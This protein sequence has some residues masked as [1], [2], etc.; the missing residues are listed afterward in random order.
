VLFLLKEVALAI[1][2][3]YWLKLQNDFFKSRAMKKIRK[4]AGGDTYTIIYLKLQL[5]SL[6]DEGHLFSEFIEDDLIDE[7]ALEIDEETENVRATL[8]FLNKCGLAEITNDEIILPQVKESTGSETS[9]AS[10][11][12]KLR[13]REQKALQCNT[14]VTESNKSVTTEKSKIR[15]DIEIKKEI[16]KEI[17]KKQSFHNFDLVKLTLKEYESCIANYGE[18][19]TI[20][21]LDKLNSFIGSKGNKY[22]SHFHTLSSWVWESVKAVKLTG[23]KQEEF[24][25]E[26]F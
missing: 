14:V 12:R 13:A 2:K 3:Y 26:V 19:Q 4:I 9:S 23:K 10:R 22:K 1:K 8:M 21:A 15:E 7:L 18:E 16:K 24:I 17:E 6:K 11:V 20:K 5:M 25:C